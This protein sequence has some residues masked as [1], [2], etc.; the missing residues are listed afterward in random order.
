PQQVWAAE[1][2][3][4]DRLSRPC[5]TLKGRW[6]SFFGGVG[7]TLG[8]RSVIRKLVIAGVVVLLAPAGC[9]AG[10]ADSNGCVLLSGA[11]STADET[12]D[13]DFLEQY[14]ATYRFR[15]GRPTSIKPTPDG[16]AVLFLRSGPRSFEHALY[17]YDVGTARERLVV[18]A[19]ALLRGAEETLTPEERARRER[20]RLVARGIT[21]FALSEEGSRVLVP[22]SGRLFVLERSDGSAREVTI[23]GGPAADPQL[24]PDG[25]RIAYVKNGDL[26]VTEIASARERRLT[27]DADGTRTNGLAEFVAQEEMGRHHGFWWSPDATL[28]AYQQTDTAGVE[29]L[30]IM[31][32]TRP[33][34][35]PNRWPYPRAGTKNAEVRLGIVAAEGGPTQWVEWDRGRYPYLASVKWQENAPLTVLIQNRRQTAEALL[36]V[37]TASGRTRTLLVERDDAWVALDQRMPHWLSDG[38]GFLWTTERG[39]GWRL[40]MRDRDGRLRHAITPPRFGLH[41]FVHL[42]EERGRIYVLAGPDPTETHLY[43]LPLEPDGS[44]PQRISE[45][46]GLHGAVFAEKGAVF[47]HTHQ[48]MKGESFKVRGVEGDVLG[49]LDSVAETPRF[50]LDL[51]GTVHF[52][53]VEDDPK[54][55]AVLI[56]PRTFEP[57]RKYPVLLHVYGGPTGQMVRKSSRGYLLAQWIADHGYIVVS[58]DGR[59]TPRRGRDWQRATK[60]DLIDIPLQDQVRGLRM[61]TGACDA[62]DLSRV[63]I[64]GWSFGGYFSAMAVMRRPDVF[65]AGVAGAPVVDWLD[66]DT[67]YTERYMGLPQENLSGYE[68]A[69]VL[70]YAG[71]LSRPLLVIH[72]TADDN[73][74]FMHSLKL[75]DALF[76]AGRHF[77]LL[78]LPGFT[79]MVPDPLVTRRLYT[80][81]V[82]FFDAH[83]KNGDAPS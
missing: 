14:A 70:T 26:H 51:S 81:I 67:H 34:R 22:L 44:E 16:R 83:L 7:M 11:G 80:R 68:A 33:Q 8:F 47:V 63:G 46:A 31:D 19:Q 58:I 18:T 21:S 13:P 73:V 27:Q 54:L 38:N 3:F 59:G 62:L 30:S 42:D 61:L 2:G 15:L 50:G 40:E 55:H 71:G 10:S 56:R 36:A 28:I 74:Y 57:D 6:F 79:H 24:S 23:D 78:P 9:S 29:V 43:R 35:P 1:G 77:E 20:K 49:E 53:T 4:P 5:D 72:G 66:Y 17:E 32:P 60:N 12:P 39:G 48:G 75:A 37:D 65:H 69:N 25:T 45:N 52:T 64:Y 41:G 82:S 76:R